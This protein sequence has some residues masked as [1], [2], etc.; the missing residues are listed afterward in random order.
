M[1]GGV[2][3]LEVSFDD[4]DQLVAARLRSPA[5]RA[6]RKE[7]TRDRVQR[8]QHHAE[9]DRQPNRLC[10]GHQTSAGARQSPRIVLIA[11]ATG[12]SPPMLRVEAVAGGGVLP[13]A[14]RTQ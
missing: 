10:Q 4:T 2:R 7:G 8:D 1:R 6:E 3:A 11:S 14:R 5:L 12:L 9:K 13:I